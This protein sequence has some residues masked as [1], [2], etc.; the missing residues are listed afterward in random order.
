MMGKGVGLRRDVRLSVFRKVRAV[1]V[2]VLGPGTGV[3]LSM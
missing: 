3:G 1:R 2:R